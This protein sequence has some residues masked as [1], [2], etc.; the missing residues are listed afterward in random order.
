MT[1]KWI[2]NQEERLLQIER[3]LRDVVASSWARID[4][5][6]LSKLN[7]AIGRIQAEIDYLRIIQGKEVTV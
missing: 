2:P 3:E 5:A 4:G 7:M 6:D 1:E